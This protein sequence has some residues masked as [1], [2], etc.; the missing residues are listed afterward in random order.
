MVFPCM[1]VG[2]G[3]C[4]VLKDMGREGPSL[5]QRGTQRL[6]PLCHHKPVHGALL[7]AE[8]HNAC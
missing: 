3:K 6:V 1:G 7:S 5:R 2:C 8:H 4:C